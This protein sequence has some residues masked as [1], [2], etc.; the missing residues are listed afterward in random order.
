ML[1][2]GETEEKD[3]I[4]SA[5]PALANQH[6]I[7]KIIVIIIKLIHAVIYSK[8]PSQTSKLHV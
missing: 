7:I 4:I 5:S 1:K 3:L 2:K 8:I 6:K